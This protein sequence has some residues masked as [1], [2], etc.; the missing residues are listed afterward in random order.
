MMLLGDSVMLRPGARVR[1]DG[2]PACCRSASASSAA[3]STA[4]PADRRRRAD[5]CPQRM[6][7][8]RRPHRRA[9]PQPGAR[10]LR[11]RRPR[12][13]RAHHLRHRP[14][15]RHHGRIG[16]RQVGAA[17]HDRA[18]RR[19]RCRRRRADRRARARSLRFRRSGTCAGEGAQRT[20][21][22]AVPADHA[23]NLRLRG[24]MLATSIAEYFRAQRQAVLLIMDSLTRVAH[25]GARDRPA[26]GRARRGARLS[27]L[28]AR[29]R[30]PSWSSAPA[31]RPPAAARS[32]GSTRCSPTATTRTIRWST[33]RARSSTGIS[34]CRASSPSAGNIRRSTSPPR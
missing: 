34:C 14:A 1:P 24:A 33:P 32:P 22:V 21:V 3:R 30:S 4:R 19:G 26:A 25:A 5:P 9:R 6:A 27:A 23:P 31:I 16:R 10:E 18:R 13:Q 8:G 17:R 11:Y 15:H 29:R 20:V 2:R 28:G 7:V 12:A